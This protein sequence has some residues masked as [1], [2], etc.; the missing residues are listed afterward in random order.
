MWGLK[1]RPIPCD[2]ICIFLPKSNCLKKLT[3][4]ALLALLVFNFYGYRLL[5]GYLQE[6]SSAQL[7][8]RVD[9]LTYNR[10]D[11]VSVKTAL[12]LPYYTGSSS[13]ERVYGSVS[14]D[15]K[16]YEYVAR[17]VY[18]D[19]LEIL[20]LPNHYKTAMEQAEAD[21]TQASANSG[22]APE[23]GGA[24]K[25]ALP[26]FLLEGSYRMDIP[27]QRISSIFATSRTLFFSSNFSSLPERPPQQVHLAV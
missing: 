12:H 23:K 20:C 11:L 21:M 27:A 10:E 24:L 5:I 6:G 7:E 25:M 3:A 1:K 26:D 15:G 4:I 8:Q 17:R 14:I 19:T 2:K 22:A 16:Y 13:F 18:N 9:A